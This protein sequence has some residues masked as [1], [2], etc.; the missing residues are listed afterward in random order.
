MHDARPQLAADAAQV[1]DVVE[2]RVHQRAVGVAGGRVHDHAG[3]L[4]DDHDVGVLVDD[5]QGKRLRLRGGGRRRG[6][7]DDHLLLRLDRQAC[8][9]LLG[10]DAAD[11]DLAVL[12]QALDLRARLLRQQR[13]EGGVEAGAG[14]LRGDGERQRHAT[15]RAAAMSRVGAGC[16]D[17]HQSI[18]RLSGTSTIEMI[19]ERE[20]ASPK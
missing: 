14:V 19:C 9:D 16:R 17:S 18:T 6:D 2:Q 20:T 15:F 4:V 1:V 13:G 12:D 8:L 7:V 3:G 11:L 10:L 5:V